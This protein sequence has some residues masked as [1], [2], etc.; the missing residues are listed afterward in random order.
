MNMSKLKKYLTNPNRLYYLFLFKF[1][2]DKI[3]KGSGNYK[4]VF[5]IEFN[6]EFYYTKL[7]AKLLLNYDINLI[8]PKTFNEKLIHRR[9]FSRDSIW[10]IITDKI[11]VRNWLKKKG[12]LESVRLVPAKVAFSVS[13]LMQVKIDKPVVVKAAWA[14]GMNL[15]V[16][17]S[18]QLQSH[19]A[20]LEHWF[21]SPYNPESLIWA[22][23]EMKRGFI[24]EDSIADEQGIVPLDYKFF[25][26]NGEIEF[27]QIDLDRFSDH[28]RAIVSVD[29]ISKG[30]GFG[31]G[32]HKYGVN[33]EQKNIIKKMKPIAELLSEEFS[34][35]RVDLYLYN[36]EV[37]FGELTQ[38]PSAG[39][40]KFTKEEA[41]RN[42][43]E[44]WKYPSSNKLGDKLI[45]EIE[46]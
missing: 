43:G 2:R 19:R 18:K 27:V 41:D 28:K 37:Y 24:I 7:K 8:S 35:V 6:N 44:A 15:F 11:T 25:C 17:S 9:L 3:L 21:A 34:F 31:K 16:N 10:P 33:E 14:S 39:F 32:K 45:E 30:W 13:D 23:E 29:G 12:Y 4:D 22:A 20:I 46:L 38:T 5:E 1:N 42:L 26:F 36:G 40:G